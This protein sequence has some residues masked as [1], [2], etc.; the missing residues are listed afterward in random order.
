GVIAS[1]LEGG[2]EVGDATFRRWAAAAH[3]PDTADAMRIAISV[4]QARGGT[5][6]GVSERW[7]RDYRRAVRVAFRDPV[8]LADLAVDGED[9]VRVGVGAGPAVGA[10]LRRLLDHVLEH[11]EANQVEALLGLAREWQDSR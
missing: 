10:M 1:G 7:G 11:P 9:L 2:H 5:P 6:P 8:A 3:R 4:L